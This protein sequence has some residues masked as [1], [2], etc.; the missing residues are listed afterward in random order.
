MIDLARPQRVHVVGV[1]G[2]A[3]NAIATVL[4]AMGHTVTG[5]D[6]ND[7]PTLERLRTLGVH[8]WVGHRAEQVEG[9][10][11]VAVST[12]IPATNEEVTA[13]VHAG[14]PVLRRAEVMAAICATRRTVAVS[15]THGKT[16][17]TGMLALILGEA[18]LNPSYIVGGEVA[19]LEGGAKWDDGD[20]LVVE[21]DESDG[22]FVELP[23]AAVVVT[24]VE[25]DHLDHY[26]NDF[27]HLTGAFAD[28]IANADDLRIVC[29]DDPIA[30][31]LGAKYGAVTYGEDPSSGYRI[32]DLAGDRSGSRFTL[33]R[34]AEELGE[35]TVPVLGG[36]NARNAAGAIAAGIELGAGFDAAVRAL[37][38]YRGIAR[39]V[40]FRGEKDGVTFIDDYAHLPGE[41]RPVLEAIAEGGWRRV[42]CVFEPHRYSRTER[43][44]RDFAAAFDRADLLVVTDIYPAF[45]AP[46]PGVTGDLIVRAVLEHRP[47]AQVAYMPERVSVAPYLRARLRPGDVCVTLGA[48]TLT[49]LANELLE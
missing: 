31:E 30:A 25:P 10:D 47:H 20:L 42:V 44:W 16:T 36:H 7:S 39:R 4:V 24:S 40:Q 48:G 9:A 8:V 3:M 6:V 35:V 22:T 18:G 2:A 29:A 14:I 38:G 41:V 32:V 19:G 34:G 21:A 37:A 23:A 43:L 26:E 49:T 17:T 45:E 11:A 12:A 15:G 1:G 33:F 28:F 27:G 13:A 46:R 5:S